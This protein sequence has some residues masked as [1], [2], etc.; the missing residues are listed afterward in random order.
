VSYVKQLWANGIAGATPLSAARLGYIETGIEAATAA[1]ETHVTTTT[2]LHGVAD[3]QAL[4][5]HAARLS[6]S[7]RAKGGPIGT[8]GKG[9]VAFRVDHQL[10][11]FRS[12][13][14]PILRDRGIPCGIGVVTEAVGD[15]TYYLDPTA[16]TWAQLQAA[17][18]EG[19]EVWSHSASH[20]DPAP[21]GGLSLRDEI[22][23]SR[24]T[25][26]A[27]GMI[28]VGWQMPGVTPCLTANYSPNFTDNAQFGTEVGQLLLATYGLIEFGS[29]AAGAR[30]VLPTD[31]SHGLSFTNI[32]TVSLVQA[33]AQVDLAINYGLGVEVIHH[34]RNIGKPGYMSTADF[35]ALVDY[36]LAAW[37]AET[38]EVL[39]PSGLAFADPGRTHRFNLIRQ[40]DF[41]GLSMAGT[42]IGTQWNVNNATGITV[43]TSGGHSGSNFLRFSGAVNYA[44]QGYTFIAEGDLQS[45]AFLA[46]AWVRNQSGSASVARMYLL[47]NSGNNPTFVRDIR[48]NLSAGQ[49]WT[50]MRA[51]FCI[52]KTCTNL[53]LRIS[54]FSGGDVDF[55]DVR[56]VSA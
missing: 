33:K 28:P 22:V 7:R 54:R 1:G 40:G 6:L 26:E 3:M 27:N 39:T 19:A 41:E 35:T 43:E 23:G 32:E 46:D 24:E 48:L 50:K 5:T 30:R 10:D 4:T 51:P 14:W 25:L 2:G 13:T 16:T 17:H 12:L 45:Q 20:D 44:F 55:D 56:I 31:G 18:W 36:V 21:H 11:E 29:R 9:V 49:G 8:S 34:P 52:P 37:N 47:D 42:T 53:V 38:L 15:A